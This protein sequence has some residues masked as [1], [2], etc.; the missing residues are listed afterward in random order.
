MEAGRLR[1]KIIIQEPVET[2][3]PDTGELETT[4]QT[5]AE[6]WAE[7]LPAIGREY[8]ASKQVIAEA[9]GKIRLR[10]I[11]GVTPKMRVVHGSRI[12]G[13]EAVINV[14]EKNIELVL[15]VSERQ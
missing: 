1:H 10:Y 8:W 4:W 3:N 2:E 12:Y 7:I 15:I 13:I 5:F 6:L 9:T 14:E 11:D